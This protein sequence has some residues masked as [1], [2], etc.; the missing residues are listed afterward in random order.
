MTSDCP[1]PDASQRERGYSPSLTTSQ[2]FA[3]SPQE[4]A[5]TLFGLIRNIKTLSC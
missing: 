4:I 2:M 3:F 5:Q 1:D